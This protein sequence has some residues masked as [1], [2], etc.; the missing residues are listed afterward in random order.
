ML[1]PFGVA[2]AAGTGFFAMLRGAQKGTF[3]PR[4]V[5]SML[6]GHPPPPF[7]LDG[8][9]DADLRG[10]KR[11]VLVNF[12]ASWCAPCIEES[13]VLLDLK[14]AGADLIGIAWKD[15]PA[16]TDRFLATHGDPFARRTAD[17]T[18][19]VAIDWGVTG[20]PETYLVSGGIV[21]WRWTSALT[22]DSVREALLPALRAAA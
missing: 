16:D 22:P 9:T 8:L 11:P 15:H 3:D 5:P 2:V 21:R 20:V 6:I 10:A 13:S 12:F 18:G 7:V 1:A 17:P 19:T 4:G 14:N